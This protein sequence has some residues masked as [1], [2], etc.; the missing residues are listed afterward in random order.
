MSKAGFL[1]ALLLLSGLTPAYSQPSGDFTAPPVIGPDTVQIQGQTTFWPTILVY[2]NPPVAGQPILVYVTA[3]SDPKRSGTYTSNPF[4]NALVQDRCPN[5]GDPGNCSGNQDIDQVD[6]DSLPAYTGNPNPPCPWAACNAPPWSGVRL[7]YRWRFIDPNSAAAPCP[8][9]YDPNTASCS[10]GLPDDDWGSAPSIF[11]YR[12]YKN[13]GVT[14]IDIDPGQPGIQLAPETPVQNF[15]STT[16]KPYIWVGVIKPG[17]IP[18]QTFTKIQFLVQVK[19]SNNMFK[20]QLGAPMIVNEGGTPDPYTLI[21]PSPPHVLSNT[22]AELKLPLPSNFGSVAP[23]AVAEKYW[24]K[25][26]EDA[27][28]SPTALEIDKFSLNPNPV[29]GVDYSDPYWI[30]KLGDNVCPDGRV[31]PAWDSMMYYV[32]KHIKD[33]DNICIKDKNGRFQK[34]HHAFQADWANDGVC[35]EDPDPYN[36]AKNEDPVPIWMYPCGVGA[37][38]S[39]GPDKPGRPCSSLQ[40]TLPNNCAG[41]PGGCTTCYDLNTGL[42]GG[43]VP[44]ECYNLAWSN[45]DPIETSQPA[46]I[47]TGYLPEHALP[48]RCWCNAINA[49]ATQQP[50]GGLDVTNVDFAYDYSPGNKLKI[51][52]KAEGNLDQ[53]FAEAGD[54]TIFFITL[55]KEWIKL[56]CQMLSGKVWHIHLWVVK[57]EAIYPSTTSTGFLVYAPALVNLL[58]SPL[59][60][61]VGLIPGLCSLT[62]LPLAQ[63]QT[64]F[65]KSIADIQKCDPNLAQ[66]VP[67]YLGSANN[68]YFDLDLTSGY[69]TSTFGAT[70]PLTIKATAQTMVIPFYL[71][72]GLVGGIDCNMA[73]FGFPL[74]QTLC[75]SCDSTCTNPTYGRNQT[76]GSCPS[77]PPDCDGGGNGA[78]GL[79][80]DAACPGG[81]INNPGNTYY[82]TDNTSGYPDL[83]SCQNVAGCPTPAHCI[84]CHDA[85]SEKAF[86]CP[87]CDFNNPPFDTCAGTSCWVTSGGGNCCRN[88][89]D[90]DGDGNDEYDCNPT[91]NGC[92]TTD[93]VKC[94]ASCSSPPEPTSAICEIVPCDCEID[95]T[96]P[97]CYQSTC[98]DKTCEECLALI[99][100]NTR[101]SCPMDSS[102]S[103]D[104]SSCPTTTCVPPSDSND[105]VKYCG[106][107]NKWH[108]KPGAPF[109][110]CPKPPSA[111]E[112]CIDEK[113]GCPTCC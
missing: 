4:N 112:S 62:S 14:R 10:P 74:L 57:I 46:K 43:V 95:T 77:A 17:A 78:D 53:T 34:G 84:P 32:G 108:V 12:M 39:L 103:V 8:G 2:P 113:T 22:T 25:V 7:Y 19:D 109:S 61:A 67:T 88:M 64:H 33:K 37:N 72:P 111:C 93:G 101:K 91:T 63:S 9:W 35:D 41:F 13:D 51:R 50:P 38:P 66:P 69:W 79:A 85:C 86:C 105:P 3:G 1:F 73:L 23:Q 71:P 60:G 81:M 87:D 89:G 28:Q 6:L 97:G 70:K 5:P 26:I 82:C 110:G 31:Q 100:D 54:C 75:S 58:N 99:E 49:F 107:D 29:D 15:S 48:S 16:V 52:L 76:E 56:A 98:A 55:P 47:S 65:Y 44:E 102:C 68:L 40:P 92:C 106:G 27:D 42:A 21:P 83:A 18:T 104:S 24:N 11:M 94:D 96:V 80:E 20:H 59:G 90:T 45:P 36:G 30:G